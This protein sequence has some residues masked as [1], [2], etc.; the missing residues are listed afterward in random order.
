MFI[1]VIL[2]V[3]KRWKQLKCPSMAEWINNMVYTHAKPGQVDSHLWSL[4]Q[5]LAS[6][7]VYSYSTSK[8]LHRWSTLVSP[9]SSE[10][11]LEFKVDSGCQVDPFP[12]YTVSPQGARVVCYSDPG[13]G[14]P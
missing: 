7:L 13:G 10:G 5:L 6:L 3:T 2:T 8:A 1:A 11:L 9:R 14:R 4:L 12:S